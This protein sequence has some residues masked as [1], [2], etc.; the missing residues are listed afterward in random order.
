MAFFLGARSKQRLK[1]VHPDLVRVVHRA[2]QLTKIDFAVGEG[3]RSYARQRM[4]V[5]AGKSKTMHSY[6]LTGDAVDLHALH[7]DT[8]KVT[9]DWQY[10]YPIA[11]AMQKAAAELCVDIEWG[12]AWS[13]LNECHDLT[14]SPVM[15]QRSYKKRGGTFMD[16]PHFQRK[17][18]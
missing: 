6:H 1:G 9:W 10:Y 5:K 3:V 11:V 16:G 14:A 13:Y 12:G 17:R 8:G 18:G 4:L 2:I 15:L 7:P